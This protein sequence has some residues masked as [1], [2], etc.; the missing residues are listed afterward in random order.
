MRYIE[1]IFSL[2]EVDKN[3]DKRAIDKITEEILKENIDVYSYKEKG[4]IAVFTYVLG[5]CDKYWIFI[6]LTFETVTMNS[7]FIAYYSSSFEKL[8]NKLTPHYRENILNCD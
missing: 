8:W 2:I 1:L 3:N 7:Y 4:E 6:Y 5:R